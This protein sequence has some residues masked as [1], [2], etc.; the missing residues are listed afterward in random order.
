LT[1]PVHSRELRQVVQDGAL[2]TTNPVAIDMTD[3]DAWERLSVSVP[4]DHKAI[5]QDI[6]ARN[7]VSL[8]RVIR[9]AIAE[10]IRERADSQLLLFNRRAS[11]HNATK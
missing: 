5:L 9:Q 2:F 11:S 7:Q 3:A 10:F 6:A 1:E 4:P 8:A